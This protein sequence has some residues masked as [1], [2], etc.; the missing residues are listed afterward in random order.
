MLIVSIVSKFVVQLAPASTGPICKLVAMLLLRCQLHCYW[1]D[2]A[3]TSLL[4]GCN[5]HVHLHFLTPFDQISNFSQR[6]L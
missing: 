5:L 2:V 4:K 3:C 1:L 6:F